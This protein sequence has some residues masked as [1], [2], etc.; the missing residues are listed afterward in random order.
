MGNACKPK[1]KREYKEKILL[2]PH[3]YTQKKPNEDVNVDLAFPTKEILIKGKKEFSIPIPLYLLKDFDETTIILLGEGSF[4]S[5]FSAERKEDL[6]TFAVKRLTFKEEEGDYDSITKEIKILYRLIPYGNIVAFEDTYT[7]KSNKAIF[8][9]MEKADSNLSSYIREYNGCLPPEI[10]RMLFIDMLFALSYSYKESVVHSDIKPDNI[11]VFRKVSRSN[12]PNVYQDKKF[13]NIVFK[14]TDFGAGTINNPHDKT[15][16]RKDMSYTANYAAPE[17]L[18]QDKPQDEN[19]ESK[20]NADKAFLVNFEKADI[21]SLGMTL[22]LCCGIE[23][24]QISHINKYELEDKHENDIKEVLEKL[25]L[26]KPQYKEFI[27]HFKEILK[28]DLSKRASLNGLVKNF[29]L[30]IPKP[31]FTKIVRK[32]KEIPKEYSDMNYHVPPEDIAQPIEYSFASEKLLLKNSMTKLSQIKLEPKNSKG[33]NW[34]FKRSKNE[35]KLVNKPEKMEVASDHN[36]P[37]SD[38]KKKYVT[39]KYIKSGEIYCGKYREGFKT[40]N[41]IQ[42]YQDGG[43]YEGNFR[44]DFPSEKGTKIF[45]DGTLFFGFWWNGL[46]DQG[47]LI[48]SDTVT[49]VGE[50]KSELKDGKGIEIMKNGTIYE[51]EFSKG[52]KSG[53]GILRKG[54]GEFVQVEYSEDMLVKEKGAVKEFENYR[55]V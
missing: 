36:L 15:K 16:F 1:K 49:Y 53:V 41:G 44:R 43:V 12:L 5:V 11:L 22:L 10:L 23:K 9:V 45:K 13:E 18:M 40:D 4:G 3:I 39:M 52:M 48:Q 27:P 35:D 50:F 38:E 33:N 20:K 42:L 2:E 21:Y 8:I 24:K 51:G 29:Q 28:F 37:K 6:K 47:I 19:E 14:L 46:I 26:Q 7:D 32:G 55:V 54:P 34:F 25:E 17:I 30:D 31:V